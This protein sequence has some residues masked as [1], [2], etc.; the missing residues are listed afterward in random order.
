MFTETTKATLLSDDKNSGNTKLLAGGL[1]ILA[2]ALLLVGYAY[3]RNRHIE[4]SLAGIPGPHANASSLPK[5]PA[6]AHVLVDD[7]M[8]K[9]G[10]TIIGGTVKN[11]SPEQLSGLSVELELQRRKDAT[12]ERMKVSVNPAQLQPTE[13]GRYSLSLRTQDYGSVRLIGLSEDSTL[14]SYT[15]APGQRRPPERLQPRVITIPRPSSGRDEFLNSPDN[16]A[17]VP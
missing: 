3:F 5:G 6:K 7:A 12:I 4:Q 10:Q 1:A 2:T 9:G 11:I 16:P 8:L 15:T 17:R 13:E 14:L